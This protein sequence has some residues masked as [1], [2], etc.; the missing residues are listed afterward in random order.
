M[1]ISVFILVEQKFSL[2]H[3]HHSPGNVFAYS[4]NRETARFMGDA[5]FF[6]LLEKLT[7]PPVPLIE[8]ESSQPLPWCIFSPKT[9]GGQSNQEGT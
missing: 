8:T 9:E 7:L 2:Q 5:V 1:R 6:T 3:G 4:Q